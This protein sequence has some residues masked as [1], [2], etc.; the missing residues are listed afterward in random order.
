[1]RIDLLHKECQ[2]SLKVCFSNENQEGWQVYHLIN[3]IHEPRFMYILK[4]FLEIEAVCLV[5]NVFSSVILNC[6]KSVLII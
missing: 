2:L 1:M 3:M 6:L 5:H 4:Y